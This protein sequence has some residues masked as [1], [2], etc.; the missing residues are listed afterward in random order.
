MFAS[1]TTHSAFA[2]N[3]RDVVVAIIGGT[4]LTLALTR[5]RL[6]WVER[7]TE[8][9]E[10]DRIWAERALTLFAFAMGGYAADAL[11]MVLHTQLGSQV[12]T[13]MKGAAMFLIIYAWLTHFEPFVAEWRLR[14]GFGAS[15][16]YTGIMVLAVTVGMIIAETILFSL[17]FGRVRLLFISGLFAG[18]CGLLYQFLPQIESLMGRIAR[19]LARR[20]AATSE[21][22]PASGGE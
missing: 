6:R 12:D 18:A 13:L 2:V 22:D 10:S 21:A 5:P 7:L 16:L 11:F 17:S 3:P 1:A 20:G 14:G 15:V 4:M 9:S 8:D 19:R